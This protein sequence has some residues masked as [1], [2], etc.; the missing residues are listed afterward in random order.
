MSLFGPNY[1]FINFEKMFPHT[2]M[3]ILSY[4]IIYLNKNLH[5][6]NTIIYFDEKFTSEIIFLQKKRMEGQVQIL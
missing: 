4:M 5:H 3:F 6:A 1:T 2:Y